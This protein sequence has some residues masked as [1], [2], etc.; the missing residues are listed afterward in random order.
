M[1]YIVPSRGRPHNIIEL[2]E[3]WD[4]TRAHAELLVCID[5]DD[6]GLDAYLEIEVRSPEWVRFGVG[7]R[8]RLGGTL[9]HWAPYYARTGDHDLI[10]FMGDDHRP[11]T[12]GWDRT[13]SEVARTA[14]PCVIYGNDLL[15]GA[16]LATAVAISSSVIDALGYMTPPGQTHL[17]L[18]NAWMDMGR[19][20][21]NL[22]YRNDV[23][24][25][26]VH[27]VAKKAEWD[28]LYKEV[29]SGE[30]YQADEKA[31]GAW[32]AEDGQ[33]AGW[34]KKLRDLKASFQ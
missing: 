23:V 13:F 21:G 16:N 32:L 22:I 26:H 29:N 25:E 20:V 28:D 11:R 19:T 5:D 34:R 30:M 33:H 6:P 31:Y 17:Y 15:Q 9:N 27:P 2:I 12:V 4:A 18:D 8:L 7:P 14:G 10:G 3:S 24:I 1:L